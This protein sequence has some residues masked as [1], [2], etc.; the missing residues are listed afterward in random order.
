MLTSSQP[1]TSP[2]SLS[3]PSYQS[4]NK[5]LASLPADE[6]QRIAPLLRTVSMSLRKVLQKQ[7]EPVEQVY[8]PSGGACSLVKTLQD[9]QV[10]EVATVGAEGAVGIGVFFGQ[11]LADCDVLVQVPGPGVEV[12]SADAFNAAM[13]RRETFFNHVIRYNQ[14]LMSQ[15]MQTTACNGLHS[16]ERR[17]CRWLLMTHDRAGTDEFRLTHELLALMLGVRRPTVTIVVASLQHAGLIRYRRGFVMIVDR[18]A[19]ETAACECYFS[20]KNSMARLLPEVGIP[21]SQSWGAARGNPNT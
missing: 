6:F 3:T 7:D 17:C 13:A 2:S 20:V 8:F 18:P 16:A 10:A 19:L 21:I 1:A 12:M 11:L 4:A 14:A 5:L 9:G 15:I